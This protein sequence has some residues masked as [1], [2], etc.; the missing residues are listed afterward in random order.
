MSVTPR[1]A[2]PHEPATRVLRQFRQVFNAVK[3]HFQQVEKQ[4]GIGGAQLWAL[5]VIAAHP[6]IGVSALAEAMDVH[7]TT[8]SNLVK[9]LVQAKLVEVERRGS[10]RRAVQ[11]R[12]TELGRSLLDEAP[13]PFTGVLPEALN[14]M[15]PATLA[16][17]E[18]D[19]T[20]LL[21][22]L[23]ADKKSARI[24]LADI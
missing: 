22:V 1:Q 6:D 12:V 10:D 23:H 9:A 8:A 20:Q 2:A 21:T 3:S 19:L 15:D 16:R 24:P 17:L 13:G 5:S 11:L 4:A 18:L 14:Q 7:Q